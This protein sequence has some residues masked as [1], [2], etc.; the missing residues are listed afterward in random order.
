MMSTSVSEEHTNL[1]HSYRIFRQPESSFAQSDSCSELISTNGDLEDAFLRSF[2]YPAKSYNGILSVESESDSL[3]GT[4][5]H[6]LAQRNREWDSASPVYTLP[7]D[8][9]QASSVFSFSVDVRVHSDTKLKFRLQLTIEYDDGSGDYP[10]VGECQEQDSS[11]GWVTC[12][13][14]YQFK[15]F[16]GS[17]KEM[18]FYLVSFSSYANYLAD[19]DFD[20]F[21]VAFQS[22]PT[23][24]LVLPDSD[25]SLESCWGANSELLVTSNNLD[26]DDVDTPTIKSISSNGDNTVT[27]EL[28]D[29]I[30]MTSNE[31]TEGAFAVEV[32]LLSRNI[33][34]SS[35]SNDYAEGG[36]LIVAHTDQ[37]QLLDGVSLNKFG[38]QGN[39]GRYVSWKE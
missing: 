30:A 20:N 37:P 27:V 1:S 16:R 12:K 15:R 31:D 11:D 32:A 19:T 8:C 22:G 5:N 29:P 14:A 21:S 7:V 2:T 34:F 18:R 28:N 33:L 3:S 39:L 4:M 25:G 35:D 6:F 36:H 10:W 38:Q 23:T 24:S 26:F 9:I 13:S 17:V